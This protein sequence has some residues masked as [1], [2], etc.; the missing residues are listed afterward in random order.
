MNFYK[1]SK[2]VIALVS[3]IAV[4]TLV[5]ILS[6]GDDTIKDALA[7]GESLPS[8]DWMMFVAY[9]VFFIITGFVL[10]S[11]VKNVLANTNSLKETLIGLG[12]FLLVLI[13]S[14]A[15]SG[16]DPAKYYENK[17]EVSESTSQVVGAGLVSLYILSF[18]SIA[19]MAWSGVVKIFKK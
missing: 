7:N 9:A 2:I 13:V 17:I 1:I 3:I 4:G 12:A 11:V 5:G 10:F 15:V 16:G 14:Y 19:V 18:I 8:L 6:L